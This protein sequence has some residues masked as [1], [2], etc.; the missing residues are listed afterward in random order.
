MS[1]IRAKDTKP[2]LTVRSLLHRLGYRYRL[3]D[4][5]LPGCPDL[6]LPRWNC[7]VFVHGCF[8]HRHSRCRYAY[9]PKSRKAFWMAKFAAN[10]SRDKQTL[11]RLRRLGWKPIVVWECE[12]GELNHLAVRLSRQISA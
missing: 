9:V 10:V 4:R 5:K 7:V 11:R 12:L 8:W 6:V 1:R 3:H 2:E